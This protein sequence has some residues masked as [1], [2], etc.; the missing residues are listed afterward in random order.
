VQEKAPGHVHDA[1]PGETPESFF[2]AAHGR[3]AVY[4]FT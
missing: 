1:V 3:V 2:T 4:Q